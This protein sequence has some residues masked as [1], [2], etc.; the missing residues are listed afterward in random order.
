LAQRQLSLMQSMSDS[1][2]WILGLSEYHSRADMTPLSS[3]SLQSTSPRSLPQRRKVD[4]IDGCDDR[5]QSPF[6]VDAID[7]CDDRFQSPFINFNFEQLPGPSSSS[8][9]APTSFLSLPHKRVEESHSADSS[10]GPEKVK[11]KASSQDFPGLSALTSGM[12][13]SRLQSRVCLGFVLPPSVLEST[14]ASSRQSPASRAGSEIQETCSENVA[15][16]TDVKAASFMLPSAL[17]RVAK[18]WQQPRESGR[19]RAD[20]CMGSGM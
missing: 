4:A 7:G 17:S 3:E 1:A 20:M 5:F 13:D 18:P 2:A 16:N 11:T 8:S 10:G 12:V 14:A 19:S 9:L 6:K 15:R